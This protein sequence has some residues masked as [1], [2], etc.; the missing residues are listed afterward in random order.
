[1]IIIKL[2]FTCSTNPAFAPAGFLWSSGQDWRKRICNIK[3][4]NFH[5]LQPTFKSILINLQKKVFSSIEMISER[6]FAKPFHKSLCLTT[7]SPHLI[8]NLFIAVIFKTSLTLA[9]F[10]RLFMKCKWI[11]LLPYLHFQLNG[12]WSQMEARFWKQI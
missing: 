5:S 12:T 4:N 6:F 1:M 3:K 9:C 10:H 2:V 7:C 11:C 8:S